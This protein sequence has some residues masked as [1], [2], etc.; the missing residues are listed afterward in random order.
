MAWLLLVG[1]PAEQHKRDYLNYSYPGRYPMNFR[2]QRMQFSACPHNSQ[3]EFVNFM[4]G[5]IECSL[6]GLNVMA[7]ASPLTSRLT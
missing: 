5:D 1:K 6:A 3:N 4:S 2:D 7:G